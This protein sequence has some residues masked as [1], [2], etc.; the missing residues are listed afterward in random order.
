MHETRQIIK[1]IEIKIIEFFRIRCATQR[2]Y[3]K[4][5]GVKDKWKN[6]K[7]II[8]GNKSRK[9]EEAI[10]SN[11]SCWDKSLR[12]KIIKYVVFNI[13]KQVATYLKL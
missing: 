6:R 13:T 4:Y 7:R 10:I 3:Y 5:N 1:M 11:K 9:Y 2:V 12:Q 8:K